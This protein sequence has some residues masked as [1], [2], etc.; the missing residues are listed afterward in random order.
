[1]IRPLGKRALKMS[2]SLV[3]LP[4]QAIQHVPQKPSAP[5]ISLNKAPPPITGFDRRT[6]EGKQWLLDAA[7]RVQ[8][9]ADR[10]EAQLGQCRAD[11][12]MGWFGRLLS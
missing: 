11:L 4:Q 12:E 3:S 1:S 7:E 5:K 10:Y 2:A 8:N 9:N 6:Y